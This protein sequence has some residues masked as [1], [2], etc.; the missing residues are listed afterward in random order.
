MK[1][2]TIITYGLIGMSV[3]VGVAGQTA[4]KLGVENLELLPRPSGVQVMV[5]VQ[6]IKSP[7]V[8]LGLFLYGIGAVTWILVLSRVDLSFAYP[9]LALNFILISATSKLILSETVPL[10][11]WVG[12][13]IIFVGILVV[14]LSGRAG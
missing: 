5:L 6:A 1:E 12:V 4:I 3:I 13:L 8:L 11:R 2:Q 10:L 14:A 7:L 9:F